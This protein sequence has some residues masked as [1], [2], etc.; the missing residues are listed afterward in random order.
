MGT[1]HIFLTPNHNS[2]GELHV[3]QL[4]RE[5]CWQVWSF[6]QPDQSTNVL[7]GVNVAPE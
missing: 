3:L 6:I 2:G 5:T 4:K 7:Q 1:L